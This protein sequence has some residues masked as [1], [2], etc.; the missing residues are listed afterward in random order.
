[1]M[2]PLLGFPPRPFLPIILVGRLCLF[3]NHSR[4]YLEQEGAPLHDAG[5]A[6]L[7]R[8]EVGNDGYPIC[9]ADQVQQMTRRFR[10][11]GSRLCGEQ[12]LAKVDKNRHSL[13][14]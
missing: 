11:S 7:M 12:V 10:R 6:R 2:R 4:D 9:L 3:R 8:A 14:T 1:M 13:F 5:L